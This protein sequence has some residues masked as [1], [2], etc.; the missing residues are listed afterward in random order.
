MADYRLVTH[1]EVG[2]RQWLIA[3]LAELNALAFSQYEGVVQV[4]PGFLEWYLARPGLRAELCQAALR[5]DRLV[6]N[7]FVTLAPMMLGG[8]VVS[9]GIVD[10]VMTHPEHRRR[11][12]ARRLMERAAEA[13]AAAGAEVSLLYTART[14]PQSGPEQLYRSL[15]YG[16][17]ELVTVWERPAGSFDASPASRVAV[18]AKARQAWERALGRRAGWLPPSDGLWRWGRE[19]RLPEY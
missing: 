1:Q 16:P 14:E 11:G 5:G 19:A 17:R 8:Q 10:T 6:S 4:T 2:D 3:E 13:M 9:C 18:D 15:G 12:L 7:V